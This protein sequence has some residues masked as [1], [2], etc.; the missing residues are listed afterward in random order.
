MIM[1]MQL[2][3]ILSEMMQLMPRSSRMMHLM[4]MLYNTNNVRLID[5]DALDAHIRG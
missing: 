2:M 4:P 3:L 5:D 1:L